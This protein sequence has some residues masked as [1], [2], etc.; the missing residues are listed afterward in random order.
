[1]F[2]QELFMFIIQRGN[3]NGLQIAKARAEQDEFLSTQISAAEGNH[4]KM[5]ATSYDCH[6]FNFY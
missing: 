2:V 4:C 5:I 3:D 6:F 1:M